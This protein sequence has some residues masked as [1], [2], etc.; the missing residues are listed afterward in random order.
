VAFVAAFVVGLHPWFCAAFGGRRSFR[1]R[2]GVARSAFVAAFVV[3]LLPSFCAAFGGR[4]SF[5][6]RWGVAR[7]AF[8]AAFVV[9]LLPSFSLSVVVSVVLWGRLRVVGSSSGVGLDSESELRH[10]IT[11]VLFAGL[12]VARR[13]PG[14]SF[15]GSGWGRTGSRSRGSRRRN[16]I[17]TGSAWSWGARGVSGGGAGRSSLYQPRRLRSDFKGGGTARPVPYGFVRTGGKLAR[18]QFPRR[19]GCVR[20]AGEASGGKRS[21][22]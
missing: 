7:W 6:R 16:G 10:C 11:L 5:R 22:P 18:V 9:G 13:V 20:E 21:G 3:G 14:G 4:R 8:V 2:R 17:P 15:S 1:R 19:R 12:A